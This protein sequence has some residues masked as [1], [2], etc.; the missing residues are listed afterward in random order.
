MCG[1]RTVKAPACHAQHTADGFV[2]NLHREGMVLHRRVVVSVL[3]THGT[4]L[5]LDRCAPGAGAGATGCG[6]SNM[7]FGLSLC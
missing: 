7:R 2:V 5:D 4:P 3:H 6:C 1:V